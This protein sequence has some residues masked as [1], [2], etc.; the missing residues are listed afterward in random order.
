MRKPIEI[1]LAPPSALHEEADHVS[2]A[3]LVI[4]KTEVEAGATGRVIDC[5]MTLTDSARLTRAY[6]DRLVLLFSGYESDPR[7]VF[8]VPEVRAFFAAI[9]EKWSAWFH[10][11]EKDGPT[12]SVILR[13]LTQSTPLHRAAGSPYV[14]AEITDIEAFR[15]L[16]LALFTSMNRLYALHGIGSE[17]NMAMTEKV[18]QCVERMFAPPD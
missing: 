16:I 3:V 15:R 13:L 2:L 6:A 18:T 4:D 17:A 10:F 12:L 8:D 14:S 1:L 7:E 5:L 11:V 9:N